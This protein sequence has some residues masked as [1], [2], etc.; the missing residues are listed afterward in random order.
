[1]FNTTEPKPELDQFDKLILNIENLEVPNRQD[2][3]SMQVYRKRLKVIEKKLGEKLGESATKKFDYT[4]AKTYTIEYLNHIL[5]GAPKPKRNLQV[6]GIER[7]KQSKKVIA[8]ILEDFSTKFREDSALI[9]SII[10]RLKQSETIEELRGALA[11]YEAAIEVEDEVEYWKGLATHL[12]NEVD[13]YD[14]YKTRTEQ[15]TE[16]IDRLYNL[17]FSED[18]DL[19]KYQRILELRRNGYKEK[20]IY[21]IMQVTRQ[22]LRTLDKKYGEEKVVALVVDF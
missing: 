21:E 6:Q 12:A 5:E 19:A 17:S 3:E 7:K 20:E 4:L 15:Y 14:K 9:K 13:E 18:E 22:E 1:M 11:V 8:K 2:E 10:K 16:E